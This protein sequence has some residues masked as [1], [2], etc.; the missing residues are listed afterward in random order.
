[1]P[2]NSLRQ[3]LGLPTRLA[4]DLTPRQ[5][6]FAQLVAR[7]ETLSA[8]Y[9]A[10]YSAGGK[11]STVNVSASKLM[12]Q[13]KIKHRVEMLLTEQEKAMHRDAVAI[14][15]HVFSGLMKES[16]REDAKPS[17]RIAALIALGKIDLVS[18]FREVRSVEDRTERRPEEVELELRSK[19]RE[20]FRHE[21]IEHVSHPEPRVLPDAQEVSPGKS[22]GDIEDV[23]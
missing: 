15:R 20:L 11:S 19:L 12:K 22:N 13:D 10:T 23:E 5:E 1:M 2:Q 16:R 9:R 7:G 17:E 3:S 14:R 6:A 18:M 4:S 21:T 8:A